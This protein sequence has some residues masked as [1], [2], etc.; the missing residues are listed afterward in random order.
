MVLIDVSC[1]AV[2]SKKEEKRFGSILSLYISEY[3]SL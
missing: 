1:D 2:K 3:N